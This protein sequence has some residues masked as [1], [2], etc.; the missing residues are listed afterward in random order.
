MIQNYI[1]TG[2]FYYTIF[3]AP[4]QMHK[5]MLWYLV[6]CINIYTKLKK[7]LHLFLRVL[8]EQRKSALQIQI[9]VQVASV[10]RRELSGSSF[11]SPESLQFVQWDN[12]P[13]RITYFNVDIRIEQACC[14]DDVVIVVEM[15]IMYT[16][17]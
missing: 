5:M 10:T 17:I 3:R 16:F 8:V 7:M 4:S 12:K 6:I 14:Q 2:E 1:L 11:Q 15:Y 9:L 13:N